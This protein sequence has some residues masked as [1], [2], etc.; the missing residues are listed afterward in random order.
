[1][2]EKSMTFYTPFP[3]DMF[4][5]P[6]PGDVVRRIAPCVSCGEEITLPMGTTPFVCPTKPECAARCDA[7]R[8]LQDPP[9]PRTS[10][11]KYKGRRTPF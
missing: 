9:E 1:M 8:R 4:Y 10:V 7:L 5:K 2:S 6:Q 11:F 3:D